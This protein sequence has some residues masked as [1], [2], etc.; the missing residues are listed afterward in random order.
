M[1][2]AVFTRALV[3]ARWIQAKYSNA[4]LLLSQLLPDHISGIFL[5]R[6]G[7][8]R[9]CAVMHATCPS[10]LILLYLEHALEFAVHLSRLF[11]FR[12]VWTFRVLLMLSSPN[13]YLIIARISVT[14]FPRFRQILIHREIASLLQ[15]KG[16][17]KSA[18]LPTCVKFCTD[19]SSS[20]GNYTYICCDIRPVLGND[21][22]RS[23]HTPTM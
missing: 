14:L 21:R 23:N 5:G 9:F 8:T 18:R 1:F 22:Q 10:R 19:G 17:K 12:W 2:M 4:A 3:L 13:A 16:G 6:G 15:I 7:G 11:Q 20:P